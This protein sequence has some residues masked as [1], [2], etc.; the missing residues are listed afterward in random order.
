MEKTMLWEAFSALDKSERRELGRFVR[1]PFFNQKEQLVRLCDFLSHCLEKRR[2]PSSAEACAAA[3]PGT[4]FDDQRL[5]LANSDLLALIEH[6]W[7]YKE[8]FADFERARI[9]LAGAYRKRNL[10]RHFQ[11]ALRE[12]RSGQERQPWRHAEFFHDQNLLEME[13]FKFASAAKRHDAFNLQEISDLMDVAYIAR[14]LRHVSYALSH[15]MVFKTEYRFGLLEAI[16]AHVEAENLLRFPAVSLYY[17]ACQF[18]TDPNAETHF[19]RFRETLTTFADQFPTDELRSLYLLA[20]NYGIKKSN[21]RGQPWYRETFELYRQALERDL[22]LEHGILS[23][24][25]YNNIVGIAGKLGE[26][27]WAEAFIHRCK[28]LLERQYREA[29]AS[30]NLAR[31]AYARKDY[32]TALM[33]LQHADYKD[34]INSMNAKILQLKIYFETDE[35][36]LLD[37][38]LESMKNYIRRQRAVGYHRDNYLNIVRFT[39]A[40]LRSNFNNRAEMDLLR[41]QIEQEQVLTEKE[42]L[43]EQLEYIRA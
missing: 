17:H 21:E 3:Y 15:R 27:D 2:K 40:L 9:R 7:M 24:F 12:A 43:L 32:H 23:R 4:P 11:I 22:L 31:V 10:P 25:A 13:Q 39:R 42:W 35:T 18:L 8:K 20:I 30:H 5:R 34:F 1:S 37:S 41:Q 33:Q 29:A 36:D 19:F 38:H 14:K 26:I 28:P 16:Y 6:F